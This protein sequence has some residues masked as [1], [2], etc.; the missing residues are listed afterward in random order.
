MSEP[1]PRARKPTDSISIRVDEERTVANIRG[2]LA[3]ALREMT[4]GE[5]ERAV[6]EGL[7]RQLLDEPACEVSHERVEH[8]DGV[9]R[10]EMTVTVEVPRPIL[11]D[12]ADAAHGPL[13]SLSHGKDDLWSDEDWPGRNAL[14]D[15]LHSRC[16]VRFRWNGTDLLNA[17][18]ETVEAIMHG[19]A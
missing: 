16:T 14:V 4:P 2:E 6:V 15:Y 19:D 13:Q 5:R 3:E 9:E 11:L 1:D 17:D 18:R 8:A 7:R 10:A 12:A